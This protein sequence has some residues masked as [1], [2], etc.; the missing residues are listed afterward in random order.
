MTC[1][2]DSILQ[3][4]PQI[5]ERIQSYDKMI[6][7]L[8]E[9]IDRIIQY[10]NTDSQSIIILPIIWTCIND[11]IKPVRDVSYKILAHI[12]RLCLQQQL[13]SVIYNTL[14]T[15]YYKSDCYK[16][17]ISFIMVI[18][19]M[20][21]YYSIKFMKMNYIP[22]ILELGNDMVIDVQ[23]EILKILPL[24]K[25]F[26]SFPE[27]AHLISTIN[28]L[29]EN[30]S[31]F[32]YKF[33][34]VIYERTIQLDHQLENQSL[35]PEDRL[36]DNSIYNIIY[37]YCFLFIE[38]MADENQVHIDIPSPHFTPIPRVSSKDSTRSASDSRVVNRRI[39]M[40][41]RNRSSDFKDLTP[42]LPLLT[43]KHAAPPPKRPIDKR[44]PRSGGRLGSFN[45]F[46]HTSNTLAP[47]S[48]KSSLSAKVTPR[49]SYF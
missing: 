21:E 14:S 47:L 6:Y 46:E 40:N 27:D 37:S 25:H 19:S 48:K 3:T 28:K 5:F 42:K 18:K 38:K 30:Y 49:S 31:H 44:L 24:C 8:L 29:Y 36:V 35:S 41:K 4:F 9:Q 15:D 11:G 23:I 20:F 10:I 39:D 12:S 7:N 45:T 13:H 17:R 33:F 1:H 32:D 22:M 34:Q 16:K 43:R 2:I 26:L